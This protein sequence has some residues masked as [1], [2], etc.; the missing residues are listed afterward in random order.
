[1]IELGDLEGLLKEVL[2]DEVPT[3]KDGSLTQ[4]RDE[5]VQDIADGISLSTMTVRIT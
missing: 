1:M 3:T 5:L 4:T 2:P